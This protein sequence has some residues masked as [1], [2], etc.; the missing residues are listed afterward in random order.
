MYRHRVRTYVMLNCNICRLW[1]L[2]EKEMVV[3]TI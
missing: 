1:K 2:S 3:T